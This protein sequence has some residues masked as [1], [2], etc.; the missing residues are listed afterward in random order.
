MENYS[1]SSISKV[2]ADYFRRN[3]RN[4]RPH[5][6]ILGAGASRQAFPSGDVQGLKLPIDND[7]I[8][9]VGL[10]D[11]LWAI[12]IEDL[13]S[14]FETIYSRIC[15]NTKIQ[16]QLKGIENH[17]YDYFSQMQLPE[18]PTLYDHLL[19]SL[20]GYD[21]VATFNW[22]PLL[23]DCWE[24]LVHRFDYNLLPSIVYLHGN[25]RVGYCEKDKILDRNGRK[26]Q[27]CNNS[28][29]LTPLL[30]PI[31]KDYKK[32]IYIRDAWQVLRV[33]LKS[34]FTITIFGYSAPIADKIAKNT[35][36][37]AWKT[38]SKRE[39]ETIFI[40]DTKTENEIASTWRPF[41]FRPSPHYKI[42]SDFY[43]SLLP[44]FA[45]RSVEGLYERTVHGKFVEA[46][47][48]PRNSTWDQL[49]AWFWDLVAFEKQLKQK[50]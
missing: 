31:E 36:L 39:F 43:D 23:F 49:D 11:K 13:N 30:F 32:N 4:F 15:D 33:F 41:F 7:F 2:T 28:L 45:R 44:R 35:M 8:K 20:R 19:L 22:D 14:G 10:K 42:N 34:A 24:R 16:N 29:K 18:D 17:I 37:R 25:V 1:P 21:L 47:P 12:G 5:V 3:P 27:L 38:A 46:I 40:I 48:I 26:C 6:V 9:I 50:A